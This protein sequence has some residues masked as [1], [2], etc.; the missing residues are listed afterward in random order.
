MT[1]A[2]AHRVSTSS[3][4]VLTEAAREAAQR[5]TELHVLHVTPSL[6]L[7]SE[8][9]YRAGI[10]DE[11]EKVL[12]DASIG[13]LVTKVHL[14]SGEDQVAETLLAL[15]AD[16]DL[17]VIGARRRSPVGK[18]LMGSIAQQIILEAPVPVL[19]VKAAD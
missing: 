6:D 8:E 17:L 14:G 1:V 19:V 2:V 13:G 10:L 5:E 12:A 18:F 9:A 16:A 3:R 11:V 4:V 15:A 7:D